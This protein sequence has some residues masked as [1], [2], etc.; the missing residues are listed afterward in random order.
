M[1]HRLDHLGEFARRGDRQPVII[2]C[3]FCPGLE[4][5][6][7][8]NFFG[9]RNNI[10]KAAASGGQIGLFAQFRDIDIALDIDLKE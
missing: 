3:K 4:K 6:G 7:K 2:D 8:D 10:D 9:M 1:F 5:P